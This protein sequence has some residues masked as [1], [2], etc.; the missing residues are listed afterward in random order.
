MI[1]QERPGSGTKF[2]KVLDPVD[3]S[4]KAWIRISLTFLLV[5]ECDAAG[6]ALLQLLLEVGRH[7]AVLWRLLK[8]RALKHHLQVAVTTK[9]NNFNKVIRMFI[10]DPGSGC[11]SR[12]RLF[13][14]PDP[15]L[16]RSRIRIRIKE[17]KY[18]LSKKN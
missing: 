1:I 4:G 13:S 18:F 12:I 10:P 5:D 3:Q 8:V 16:T 11:L 9:Q 15:G 7:L 17:F 6:G 2:R 14:I